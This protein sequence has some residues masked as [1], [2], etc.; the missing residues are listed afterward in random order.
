MDLLEKLEAAEGIR[1][2]IAL[3]AQLLDSHR[4]DEWGRLFSEDAAFSV[5]QA[6]YRGR[7]EIQREI[8]GMMQPEIPTKHM[9]VQPVIDFEGPARA[10]AWTDMA[11]LVTDE[12]GIARANIGRYHDRLV[13]EDERWRFAARALV[14][15]GEERPAGVVESP[16]G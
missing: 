13:F 9:L 15:A 4:Y 11:G 10:L 16:G 12:A 1:R 7:A 8:C 5:G 3:Y 14:I 6:T 2:L